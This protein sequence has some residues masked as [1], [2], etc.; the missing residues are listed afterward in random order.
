MTP[1]RTPGGPNEI[2]PLFAIRGGEGKRRMKL[3][4]VT[5]SGGC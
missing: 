1:T 3:W 4:A 2:C 5:Y